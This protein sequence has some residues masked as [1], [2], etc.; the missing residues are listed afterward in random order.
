MAFLTQ[1]SNHKKKKTNT[2]NFAEKF[3]KTISRAYF[4]HSKDSYFVKCNDT[5]EI[6]FGNC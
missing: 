4:F 2:L 1:K 5:V 6:I 3:I